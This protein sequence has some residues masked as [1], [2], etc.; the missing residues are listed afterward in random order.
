MFALRGDINY[1]IRNLIMSLFKVQI[2]PG[3]DR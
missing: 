2:T 3:S 1:N